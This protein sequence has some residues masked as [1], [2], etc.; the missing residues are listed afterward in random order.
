MKNA[1]N[2]LVFRVDD[3]GVTYRLLEDLGVTTTAKANSA[4]KRLGGIVLLKPNPVDKNEL[5]K[6]NDNGR[7]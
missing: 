4:A 3:D 6:E 2:R 1:S 7:V 5:S